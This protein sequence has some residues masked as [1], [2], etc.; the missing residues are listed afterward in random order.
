M[1]HSLLHGLLLHVTQD[2]A[3]F[4][5]EQSAQQTA[6]P[7]ESPLSVQIAGIELNAVPQD[8]SSKALT[9]KHTQA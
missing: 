8:M 3:E 9:W 1:H 2:T 6:L 5:D 7:A 4:A